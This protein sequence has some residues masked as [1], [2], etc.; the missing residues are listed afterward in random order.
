MTLELRQLINVNDDILNTITTW[1]IGG[2]F[3]M[4]IALMQ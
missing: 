4:G 2:E 3:K 1:I